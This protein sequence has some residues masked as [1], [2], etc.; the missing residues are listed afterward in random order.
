MENNAMS[1]LYIVCDLN[2]NLFLIS[3]WHWNFGSGY[4]TWMLRW[5]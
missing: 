5:K 3:I 4:P 2:L 1:E